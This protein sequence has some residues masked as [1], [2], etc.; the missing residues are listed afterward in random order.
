MKNIKEYVHEHDL[1][2]RP[3][4]LIWLCKVYDILAGMYACQVWGA[5]YLQDSS[6]FKIQLQN[7][8]LGS[9][10]RFLDVKSTATNWP[11]LRECGQ[12]PLQT[13]WFRAAL[14][15]F[16]AL[17]CMHSEDVF[18]QEMLSASKVPMQ[19]FFGDLRYR[20]KK[21]LR[22]ADALSPQEV[23]RKAVTYHH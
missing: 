19:D 10:R 22:K 4:T 20:Q 15:F 12:E 7:R 8:Q 9:L 13:Y 14:K 6:E 5:D 23:N 21:I 16:N 1:R 3:N 18:K 2:N 17:S 11:V